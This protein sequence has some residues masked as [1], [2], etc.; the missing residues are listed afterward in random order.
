M[1]DLVASWLRTVVPGLWSAVLGTV[2]GWLAAHA[3]WSLDLL[4]LLNIDP[5]TE[6]FTA[7]VVLIV[8][9]VWYALWRKAEPHIPDWLTR[10]VLGS[11]LT[12]A[13]QLGTVYPI[14]TYSTGDS[15]RLNDGAIVTI[16]AIIMDPGAESASYEF[17]H[18]SG[19]QGL[20]HESDVAGLVS[21]AS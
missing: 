19:A 1:S 21:R 2:L 9:A 7:G 11:S 14:A 13:Y 20:A 5:T 8:L 18:A 15:V 16:G 17:F 12:P 6:R 3:A 4:E 10:I